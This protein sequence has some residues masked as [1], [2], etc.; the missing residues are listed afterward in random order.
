MV[1]PKKKASSGV[2]LDANQ[3]DCETVEHVGIG[4]MR[5]NVQE[6][7]AERVRINQ[8]RLSSAASVR[9]RENGPR[10]DVGGRCQIE[11]LRRGRS[12]D[13]RRF[14]HAS[15]NDRQHDGA[16][17]SHRRARRGNNESR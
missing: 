5:H 4:I 1:A 10:L 17:R 9:Y 3:E 13:C 14:Y 6:D 2:S 15:C 7:F 12:S 8:H 16:L 11:G